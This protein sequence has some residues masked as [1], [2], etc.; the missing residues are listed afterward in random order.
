MTAREAASASGELTGDEILGGPQGRQFLPLFVLA[1]FGAGITL[2]AITGAAIPKLLTI[3]DEPAKEDNLALVSAVGGIA[4]TLATPLMGRLSDRTTS[5]LGMRRPWFLGGLAVGTIGCVL[6]ALAGGLPLLLVGW[7]VV[8]LGYGAVAMANHTL[9]AD[10]V[11]ARI[12]ARVAAAV[13]VATAVSTILGVGLV[14]ALP[15]GSNWTWFAV[16]GLIG[17]LAVAPICVGYR[18]AVRTGP[19]PPLR[20]RELLGSYWLDPVRYRDFAWAWASRFFMTMSI[21]TISLFLF[22]LI[23]DTLGYSAQEAGGVQTRALGVFFVGN[24]VATV[25]FGWLSD[26]LGRRRA[27]VWA[28]GLC[29]AAGVTVVMLSDGMGAFLVGMAVVGF[30]Q[31]AYIAV[32]VAL[33]TEVLPSREDAGKDLGIVALAYQLPQIIGPVV[34]AAVIALAGGDY[35]GLFVFSIVCSVLGGLAVV[36]IRGVR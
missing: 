2:G 3:L 23:I 34:G 21:L 31:G 27:I 30:A 10:Q 32:D 19:V 20:A 11:P 17:L 26:R 12:R 16:P 8:Q 18:D 25:L 1:W 4:I 33:M 24:V 15:F 29:S 14:A 5:A 36:P 28:S 22:F 9:L 35:R 13:G 7:V 6:M